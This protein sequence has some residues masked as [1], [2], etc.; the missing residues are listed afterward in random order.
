MKIDI[1]ACEFSGIIIE[2]VR[3]ILMVSPAQS[4]AGQCLLETKSL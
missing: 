4:P 2:R 1:V 3:E